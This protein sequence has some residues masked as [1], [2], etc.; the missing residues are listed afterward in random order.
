MNIYKIQ[1]DY[2]YKN[3]SAKDEVTINQFKDFKG[4]TLAGMWKV[5][6]FQLLEDVTDVKSEK[7]SE[8]TKKRDFDARS[9]GNMLFIKNEFDSLFNQMNIEL[10][11]IIIESGE[12]VFSFLNVLDIVEAIDFSNLDYQQSMEML[13]SN[14]IKFIKAHIGELQIFR[15]KKLITFYYCTEDFKTLIEVN[16]I[17][18]LE[19]EQVGAAT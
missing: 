2:S 8:Q 3:I 15:D 16:G 4:Q 5:P 10:L 14:N 19:F 12:P 7:N 17:K 13:K 11:P 9:Y 18:G 6:E 1:T